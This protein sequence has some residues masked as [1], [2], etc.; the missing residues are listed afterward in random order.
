MQHVILMLLMPLF[1]QI[2]EYLAGAITFQA[3]PFLMDNPGRG[4]FDM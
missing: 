2:K 4:E 3:P 1:P